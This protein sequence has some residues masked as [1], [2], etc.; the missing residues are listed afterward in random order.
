MRISDLITHP[1]LAVENA[2]SGA[3]ASLRPGQVLQARVINAAD[4][5][6]RLRIGNLELNA[7]TPLQ[8]EAGQRLT[9]SVVRTGSPMEMKLLRE[10]SPQAIQAQV[11][12]TALPRQIPLA[13]LMKRFDKLTGSPFPTTKAVPEAALEP[14]KP[15]TPT[16]RFQP[17]SNIA[18]APPRASTLPTDEVSQPVLPTASRPESAASV[19]APQ[20]APRE[21]NPLP[22]GLLRAVQQVLDHQLSTEERLTPARLR[23]V[24]EQ[25]G[26]FL[27]ARLAEGAE[28]RRDLK[29]DLLRLMTQLS[30]VD[31]K[32]GRHTNPASP[33][34][35]NPQ[36]PAPATPLANLLGE[37]RSQAEAGLSRILIN[38]VAALPQSDSTQ[39]VW[40]FDLP[41]RQGQ[42]SDN[43][44][45]QISREDTGKSTDAAAAGT[46]WSV[47]LQ[48]DLSDL[49]P[50]SSRITLKDGEIS[51]H[52]TAERADTV[53]RI[54]SAMPKLNQALSR[55]GLEIGSL[56]AGQ[57]SIGTIEGPAQRMPRLLDE[58][59]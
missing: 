58:K 31:P 21:N 17:G 35:D 11:L 54:A 29:S 37:L 52:F 15:A 16:D 45:L 26:L 57:G 36:Q 27:E 50:V 51:S 2:R 47:H 12:R 39:Q 14:G 6:A 33:R 44:T 42:N 34:T 1:R 24:F 5:N 49:G 28:P 43:F 13:P 20:T 55:A 19:A 59:A 25:S 30:L 10:T 41:V 8:L 46:V 18:A 4:G 7:R 23:R 53:A 32:G 22:G 9:L 48:F 56:S 38:Q 3:L 40:T